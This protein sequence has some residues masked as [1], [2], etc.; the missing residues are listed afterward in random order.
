MRTIRLVGIGVALLL[1]SLAIGGGAVGAV[2][3]TVITHGN[4]Q[5]WAFEGPD[6]SGN[7]GISS[8]AFVTGPARWYRHRECA[9]RLG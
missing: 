6:E 4:M 8:G 7:G 9:L 2:G 3:A 5:G 1:M